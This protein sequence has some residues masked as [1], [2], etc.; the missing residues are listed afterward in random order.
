M[1]LSG[2]AEVDVFEHAEGRLLFLEGPFRAK[3]V[4]ADDQDF[5]RLDFAD[6]FRVNEVEGTGLGGEDVGAVEFA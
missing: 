5:A 2:R 4:L 3:A 1:M 6:E